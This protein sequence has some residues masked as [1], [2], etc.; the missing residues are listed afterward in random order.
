MTALIDL[1][2]DVLDAMGF[3]LHL[4][5]PCGPET[6]LDL[7]RA[8]AHR[9]VRVQAGTGRIIDAVMASRLATRPA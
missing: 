4:A 8:S 6:G 2:A 5:G 3:R 9:R 1:V 7:S